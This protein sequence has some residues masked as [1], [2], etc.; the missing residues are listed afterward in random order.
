MYG[1][2]EDP[3]RK[4][5]HITPPRTS[6]QPT[7]T[8]QPLTQMSAQSTSPY[9]PP[10]SQLVLELFVRSLPASLSF[11]TSLGFTFI[12]QRGQFVELAWEDHLLYLDGSHGSALNLP[13]QTY[14][15]QAN[16]RVMVPDVDAAWE[17]AV[18]VGAKVLVPIQDQYYGLRDFTIL[19][20]D[21]FGVRFGTRLPEQTE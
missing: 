10:T 2:S 14:H 13:P 21:G 5:G 8:P 17:R 19:D 16:V 12:A 3:R 15:P 11:Y 18:A 20:P 4:L 9:V 7:A 6:Q 1:M